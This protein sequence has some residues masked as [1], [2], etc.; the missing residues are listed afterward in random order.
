MRRFAKFAKTATDLYAVIHK[1]GK[2]GKNQIKTSTARW[3]TRILRTFSRI[4]VGGG[5]RVFVMEL[6]V[7]KG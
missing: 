5:Y 2:M 4:A 1:V 7:S 3:P 6:T